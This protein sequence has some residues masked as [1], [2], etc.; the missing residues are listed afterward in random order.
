MIFTSK[1]IYIQDF[2]E[3]DTCYKCEF[4]LKKSLRMRKCSESV[5]KLDI[6]QSKGGKLL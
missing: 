2:N 6:M 4:F 1:I 5:L 3:E